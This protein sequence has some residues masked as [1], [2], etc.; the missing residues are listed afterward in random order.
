MSTPR[1]GGAL[2]GT[3][4]E[5]GARVLIID[6]D[7]S[8]LRAVGISLKVRGYEVIVARRGEEGL[9]LAA[10]KRPDV[11]LLDLGLPGIDGVEVV[12]GLRGWSEFPIIVL[13]ARDQ[14]S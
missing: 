13:S 10:H 8:L 6:D 1:S 4:I 12:R 14:E 7:V 9:D 3:D 2:Q 11:I 5:I